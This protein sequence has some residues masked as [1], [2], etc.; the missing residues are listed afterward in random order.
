MAEGD[1]GEKTLPATA[2]KLAD[3]RA[4]GDIPVSR[5]GSSAGGYVAAL[6]AV[7]LL[8]GGTAKAVGEMIL[9]LFDQPDA[10]VDLNGDGLAQAARMALSALALALAP[11]F[12]LLIAS[13][14]LPHMLQNSL[15]VS[16]ARLRPKLSN[17]S[18]A[19]GF[20]RVIGLPPLINFG[21]N[22]L[23]MLVVGVAC[24]AVVRPIYRNS[25]NLS[26]LD[27][28][29]LM[30]LLGQDVVALLGAVTLIT[31][32]IAAADVSYQRWTYARKHR[33]SYQ[34]V[35]D[36]M[37]QSDGNPEIKAKLRRIRM[38]RAQRRMM[39]D[40]PKASVVITNPTHFAI[41]LRYERGVD[42]AP[43]VIAKGVDHVAQRIKEVAREAGVP[44]MENRPLA[45]ALHASVEIGQVIPREH[46]EAVAKIIGL[47][48]AQRAPG[49]N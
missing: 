36:E 29:A 49:G 25:A 35:R 45:R 31:V 42:A 4:Q 13:A 10:F 43:I 26:G 24:F 41:A 1:G 15:T 44:L 7:A 12:G 39:H 9:P 3:A 23:K 37:R 5:E 6:F 40:V 32:G 30:P 38:G 48:W 19:R 33:M 46:F 11:L 34:E 18:L 20:K 8:G 21:K 17:L 47:I 2:K 27:L 22:M 14:I 28:H 16:G